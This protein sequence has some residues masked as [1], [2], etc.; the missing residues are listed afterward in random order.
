MRCHV[1]SGGCWQCLVRVVHG[2]VS[3]ADSVAGGYHGWLFFQLLR[4]M[5]I[6]SAP[7]VSADDL[8][9]RTPHEAGF[10]RMASVST[11]FAE[12]AM[13]LRQ[14]A[15]QHPLGD[16]L[17]LLADIAKAQQVALDA[18]QQR[19]PPVPLP[20]AQAIEQAALLGK[21]PVPAQHWP[22]DVL[23]HDVA[24]EIAGSIAF[25]PTATLAVC[26]RIRTASADWL[27]QQADF[28][29]DSGQPLRPHDVDAS[30]HQPNALA[31]A[32][33]D[34]ST[35]AKD[36]TDT[37]HG[38]DA[39]A[40]TN[41]HTQS[42]PQG[43]PDG[44]CTSDEGNSDSAFDT[45]AAPLLAAALQVYWTHMAAQLH[46]RPTAAGAPSALGRID[47]ATVC[48]CCGSQ[49]TASIVRNDPER[50]G[51]RYLH[52]A[53]CA[54]QWH[55]VRIKCSH[56]ESTKGIAYHS[57]ERAQQ[58]GAHADSVD[59]AQRAQAVVQVE[60]CDV[61]HHYLKIVHAERDPHVEAVADDVASITLDM[62]IGEAGYQPQG[63]NFF[64]PLAE[65]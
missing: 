34:Y 25:A 52:C 49:P 56:C 14:L 35:H 8:A 38:V 24:R 40:P 10:L 64:M 16:Y 18:L 23:W 28:L 55:M 54:T 2:F 36:G 20:D 29:L 51:Q 62:L 33:T 17:R 42:A 31:S 4:I 19:E 21:P 46:T 57:L 1:R 45:S 15:Y 65:G 9:A 6:T 5:T 30:T 59:D 50:S 53:L 39:D 13:R 12:R 47:D 58:T 41:A 60:T 48:P 61:C 43:M 22:R 7:L 32:D 37:D 26:A 11:V 44:K 27:E 3:G 63:V